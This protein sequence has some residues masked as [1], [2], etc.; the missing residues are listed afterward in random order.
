[1]AGP[2]TGRRQNG[3]AR[4]S[5]QPLRRQSSR[6]GFAIATDKIRRSKLETQHR[7]DFVFQ[8]S[9]YCSHLDTFRMR[10]EGGDGGGQAFSDGMGLMEG[11]PWS[12]CTLPILSH[13]KLAKSAG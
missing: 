6:I 8:M 5:S 2:M 12:T 13:V 11:S 1:M 3:V 10:T 9:I 4:D 7:A